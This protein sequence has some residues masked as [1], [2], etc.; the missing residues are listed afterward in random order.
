MQPPRLTHYHLFLHPELHCKAMSSCE[1][2]SGR[3]IS[4]VLRFICPKQ[5][6][7][8]REYW[9][10]LSTKGSVLFLCGLNC[11][12]H[13]KAGNHHTELVCLGWGKLCRIWYSTEIHLEKKHSF[14]ITFTMEAGGLIPLLQ[15]FVFV[16][17]QCTLTGV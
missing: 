7:L 8:F 3:F 13:W 5:T 17:L 1:D 4:F 16:V 9:T 14:P 11:M 6:G 10:I 2:I 12:G 15:W